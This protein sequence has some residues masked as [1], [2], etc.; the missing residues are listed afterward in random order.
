[1]TSGILD[2]FILMNT[3]IN[4]IWYVFTII[5]LLYKFTSFFTTAWGLIKF[6]GK[7][8][9]GVK[10]TCSSVITFF[11]SRMKTNNGDGDEETQNIEQN[12]EH[13]GTFQNNIVNVYNKF[14][15]SGVKSSKVIPLETIYESK[16]TD[17]EMGNDS[18]DSRLLKNYKNQSD[19]RN[20]N[21]QFQNL[22]Y[23]EN[24]D[25]KTKYMKMNKT[26]TNNMESNDMESNDINKNLFKSVYPEGVNKNSMNILTYRESDSELL[27]Q[28]EF[29][30]N[31]LRENTNKS[32]ENTNNK[33]KGISNEKKHII[34]PFAQN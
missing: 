14:F 23:I 1:M 28:S 21:Y 2:T 18:S 30:N 26:E 22:N 11:K 10:N 25:L 19:Y 15:N 5:F 13:Y 33:L 32:K 12:N 3:V 7:L 31:K 16:I 27:L 4:S 9:Y 6:T 24:Q 29:I 17:I 34:L 20:P 8:F